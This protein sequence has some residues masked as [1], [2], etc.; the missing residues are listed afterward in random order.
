[1]TCCGQPTPENAYLCNTCFNNLWIALGDV[2]ALVTELDVSLSKQRRWEY[3]TGSSS[4]SSEEALPFN[5]A[6]ARSL[7][8]LRDQLQ[9]L[10]RRCVAADVPSKDYR[11]RHPGSTCKEL[12]TWL[13][14]RIDGIAG[15]PW[16]P[17][18]LTLVKAVQHAVHVIDRPPERTFAGPCDQCGHDLYARK[19]KPTVH[20]HDCG[21]EYNLADR[22]E[23]LLKQVDDQLATASE[24][25][26]AL[27]SMELPITAER[28]RQWKHRDRIEVKAHDRLD[29]PLYR[30]GDVV[31]L[32]VEHT[33]RVGA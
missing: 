8:E 18:A 3:D 22:R 6:A 20:C 31:D 25:A 5:L 27:T 28:I 21:L 7:R 10:A 16:A 19:G 9:Q 2:P 30:V 13:M 1:M 11:Y 15:Q 33:A 24:I 32:L 12:S 4:R 23:W 14:W 29:R 17:D 26:R